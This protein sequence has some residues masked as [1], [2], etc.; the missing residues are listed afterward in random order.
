MFWNLK[1][2]M[3][4]NIE[5]N[6]RKTDTAICYIPHLGGK[7]LHLGSGLPDL[8]QESVSWVGKVSWWVRLPATKPGFLSL[9]TRTHKVEGD[10]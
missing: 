7:S 5:K 2:K 8:R 9:I 10:N 1:E 4:N 6:P 3:K